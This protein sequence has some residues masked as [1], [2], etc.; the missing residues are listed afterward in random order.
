MEKNLKQG[1]LIADQTESAIK[2]TE[3][4]LNV[5]ENLEQKTT[6]NKKLIDVTH[7]F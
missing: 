1:D 6:K 7:G 2:A 5:I 4:M 3:R